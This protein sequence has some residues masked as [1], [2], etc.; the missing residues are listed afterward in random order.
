MTLDVM[1]KA[2]FDFDFEV[3]FYKMG[4]INLTNENI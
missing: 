4:K 1:G 2:F 3:I